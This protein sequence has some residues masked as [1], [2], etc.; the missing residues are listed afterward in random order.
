MPSKKHIGKESNEKERNRKRKGK[1]FMNA[2]EAGGTAG[3]GALS[4]V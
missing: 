1:H 3:R 4:N 2:P